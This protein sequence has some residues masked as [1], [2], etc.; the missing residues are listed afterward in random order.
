[1]KRLLVQLLIIYVM[2]MVYVL[3]VIGS[4]GAGP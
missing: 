2:V 1:M 4:E 3:P